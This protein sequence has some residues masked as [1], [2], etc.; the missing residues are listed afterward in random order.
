MV[1]KNYGLSEREIRDEMEKAIQ[2]AFNNADTHDK[3]VSLF[4]ERVPSV[5]E[6]VERIA[7]Q[8]RLI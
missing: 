7:D 8:I 2:A 1:S 3:F 5:E 6:F 4:G